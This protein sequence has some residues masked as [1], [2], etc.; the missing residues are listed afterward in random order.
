[1]V[2]FI[3]RLVRTR[4]NQR[5]LRATVLCSR[6]VELV[7]SQPASTFLSWCFEMINDSTCAMLCSTSTAYQSL[8]MGVG[9]ATCTTG[10]PGMSIDPSIAQLG[11]C[12]VVHVAHVF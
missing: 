9:Q 6:S 1:M 7:E 11:T 5:E 10:P 4:I 2:E 8:H 12:R 3:T